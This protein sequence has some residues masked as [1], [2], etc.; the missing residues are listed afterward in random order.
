M[1]KHI[2]VPLD[3]SHLAEIALTA[4]LE[5]AAKF[6][7]EIT[8]LCVA[9]PPF[10][11]Y[12]VDGRAYANVLIAMRQHAH[13]EAKDYLKALKGS[14][15]QQGYIVHTQVMESD[16]PATA[17]LDVVEAQNMDAIVMSTHGR[18]GLVRWVYG[19]VADKVLRHA[20]VPV[21]LIRVKAGEFD[22]DFPAIADEAD[23]R[24]FA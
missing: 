3:G 2:L 5:I 6:E 23:I 20:D 18:G 9:L 10:T 19:S 14:L 11:I 12:S 22:A 16:S 21:I 24:E 13:D 17:I 15:R 4:A 7:S 8:L 1:F